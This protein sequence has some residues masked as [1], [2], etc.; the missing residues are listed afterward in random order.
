MNLLDLGSTIKRLRKENGLTQAE[1]AKQANISRQTLSKLE[2]GY[3]A[4]ISIVTLNEIL[5]ALHYE[6]DIKPINP[7]RSDPSK[8]IAG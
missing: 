1:L 4:H 6:L 3:I 5:G 7:F 8:I 2:N